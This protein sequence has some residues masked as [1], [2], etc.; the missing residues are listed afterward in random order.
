MGPRVKPKARCSCS[1]LPRRHHPG[2]SSWKPEAL[3]VK[4][5]TS[6]SGK[7]ESGRRILPMR[8]RKEDHAV[9]VA[10][11]DT[12]LQRRGYGGENA[13][14]WQFLGRFASRRRTEPGG[15]R[16]TRCAL[17]LAEQL[18]FPTC[19]SATRPYYSKAVARPNLQHTR[20]KR[21]VT[22]PRNVAKRSGVVA[23]STAKRSLLSSRRST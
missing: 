17:R 19:S 1:L 20:H 16:I 23:A 22:S 6:E 3:N 14:L 12:K 5:S 10:Q 18:P 13:G 4:E 8:P 2:L 9:Q 7:C 21:S 15:V 11:R